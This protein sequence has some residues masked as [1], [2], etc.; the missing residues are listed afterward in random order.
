MQE[1]TIEPLRVELFI[2]APFA[3]VVTVKEFD[4]P[5]ATVTRLLAGSAA[6]RAWA[7]LEGVELEVV[8]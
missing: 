7:R 3:V 2:E 1:L 8:P 4:P 5:Y 6:A